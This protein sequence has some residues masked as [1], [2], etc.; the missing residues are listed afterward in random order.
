[1]TCCQLNC[2]IDRGDHAVGSRHSFAGNFKRSA[3]IWTGASKWKAQRDIHAFV[4]G[5][6]LERDQPLIVVHAKN[7]VEFAF[8]RAV[9]NCVRGMRPGY[10]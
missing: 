10:F 7:R 2:K 3:M 5:V 4:K 8:D 1:M 9:E 6:Q